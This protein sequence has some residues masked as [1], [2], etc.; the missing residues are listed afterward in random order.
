[1][2]IIPYGLDMQIDNTA[3]LPPGLNARYLVAY[4]AHIPGRMIAVRW[5]RKVPATLPDDYALIDFK[6]EN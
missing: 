2:N 3:Q 4:P 5:A 1:M 6:P